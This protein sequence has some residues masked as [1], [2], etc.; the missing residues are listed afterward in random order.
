MPRSGEAEYSVVNAVENTV[1]GPVVQAGVVHGDV[2]II[3]HRERPAVP[4]PRQVPAPPPH[5][6]GRDAELAV[7]D[8]MLAGPG[9]GPALLVITGVGGVGKSALA[10][11]WIQGNA[12][13]YPDGQLYGRLGAFDPAG[14]APPGELLG[15]LLRSLDV[16][17][18]RVPA[19][20]GERAALFRSLTAQRRIVLLLD[21][22]VSAA[23]VRPL[24]PISPGSAVL[25]TARWQLTGLTSDGARFLPVAPFSAPTAREFLRRTI[26]PERVASDP[27]A[28]SSLIDLCGGLPI[29]LAVTGARLATR[30]LRSVSRAVDELTQEQRRLRRLGIREEVSV[31]G[32]FDS[33][34]QALPEP[35]AR[36]YRAVGLHPGAEFG[37]AVIATAL[38]LDAGDVGELLDTLLEASLLDE[39]PAG[40]YRMHDLVRL[41]ARQHAEADPE[42]GVL[43][44]RITE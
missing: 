26:G 2:R 43:T 25:V 42:H 17:P 7:M 39:T 19:G 13:H 32:A 33:S 24:L 35:A 3:H 12:G 15:Q 34:Y 28:T 30:P 6:V 14:P 21:N 31:Q 40:R 37:P 10:L 44:R 38:G 22:A 23:Q 8:R 4:V 11:R 1:L 29:A 16:E 18:D 9:Q 27:A 41:H 20:T 36:C 5:F